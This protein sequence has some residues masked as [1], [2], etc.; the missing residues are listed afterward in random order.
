MF[1]ILLEGLACGLRKDVELENFLHVSTYLIE[2]ST[3]PHSNVSQTSA[4][5]LLSVFINKLSNGIFIELHLQ[6]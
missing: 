6:A 2:H 5:R 1:K 4:A 3:T